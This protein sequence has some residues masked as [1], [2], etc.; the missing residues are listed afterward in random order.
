MYNINIIVLIIAS[1][2]VADFPEIN[3]CAFFNINKH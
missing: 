2:F 3:I 1:V